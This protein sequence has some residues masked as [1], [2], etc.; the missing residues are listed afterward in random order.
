LV[1][2]ERV[3]LSSLGC[4]PRILPLNDAPSLTARAVWGI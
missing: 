1:D 4:R 3:E 2:T